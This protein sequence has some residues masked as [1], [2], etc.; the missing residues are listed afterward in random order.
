MLAGD[1]RFKYDVVD[2][3]PEE[4]HVD[5]DLFEMGTE[6]R[7]APLEADVVLLLVLV[8][9]EVVVLLID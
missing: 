7:E 9:H 8:L 3:G 1:E 6:G 2:A 4:V 5:A